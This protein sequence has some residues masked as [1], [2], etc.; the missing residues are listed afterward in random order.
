MIVDLKYLLMHKLYKNTT[1]QYYN[2]ILYL[3]NT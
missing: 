3:L 2:I 1:K